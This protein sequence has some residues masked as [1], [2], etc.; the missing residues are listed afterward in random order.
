MNVGDSLLEIDWIID[1]CVSGVTNDDRM[2]VSTVSAVVASF[3][4]FAT[5]SNLL[6]S[7]SDAAGNN[8]DFTKSS[9]SIFVVTGG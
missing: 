9:T 1:K 6:W 7:W 2:G 5:L 8:K 4:A 3:S